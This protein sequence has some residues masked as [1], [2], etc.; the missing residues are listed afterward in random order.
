MSEDKRPVVLFSSEEIK[1]ASTSDMTINMLMNGLPDK[2][3]PEDVEMLS[4]SLSKVK[5]VKT[6]GSADK[7]FHRRAKKN[8]CV[9]SYI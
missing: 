2:S 3:S 4:A 5:V 9:E 6:K 8:A 1:A 7:T